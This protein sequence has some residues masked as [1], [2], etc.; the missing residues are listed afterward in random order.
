MLSSTRCCVVI[1]KWIGEPALVLSVATEVPLDGSS[2]SITSPHWLKGT[3]FK[4]EH[5][6]FLTV[7][8]KIV[9]TAVDF[10]TR[11]LAFTVS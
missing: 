6:Y 4:E 3:D 8:E 7:Q 11:R 9:D 5:T 1:I 10:S 2:S